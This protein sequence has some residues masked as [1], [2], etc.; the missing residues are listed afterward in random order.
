MGG[1]A[2]TAVVLVNLGGPERLED[3]RP[4]LKELFGDPDIFR[5]PFGSVGQK[6]FSGIIAKFRA[7]KSEGYYARIGG[8][9]PI[10]R[11]TRKQAAKLQDSLNGLGNYTVFTAQ[12][13]WKPFIHETVSELR[14]GDFSRIVLIPLFPQYSTTTTLSVINE[15]KRHSEG[16]PDPI[17][18]HRF[19]RHP[20][21]VAACADRIREKTALFDNAPHL[22][23]SA[24]SIP[25][26]RVTDGDPYQREIEE[27]VRL[28]ASEMGSK[29]YSLCYQS[30]V[31]PVKWLGPS[32]GSHLNELYARGVR[33]L[34][35]FPV[36]F[37]SEHLETLYEL[38]QKYKTMALE[39]GF[40]RVERALTVQDSHLFIKT[41]K[42]LI[43]EKIS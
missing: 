10:V 25:V 26:R 19:Y 18:V 23:F 41:L 7:P 33:E 36:A 27:S 39:L 16:L 31:G 34:V 37:V 3:V 22:L 1:S 42:T 24:H 20:Q 5:F 32:I 4:F 29:D 14:N 11:N 8:G 2:K 6:I 21:F 28:I 40:S 30:R 13:Y 12:R 35:I 43:L 15:W 9:S 38:D 17:I